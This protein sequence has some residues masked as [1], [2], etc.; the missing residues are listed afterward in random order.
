VSP[1]SALP[2]FLAALVDGLEAAGCG[3]DVHGVNHNV[4]STIPVG[5]DHA[6]VVADLSW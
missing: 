1:W 5:P 6:G 2:D 3:Y 4:G